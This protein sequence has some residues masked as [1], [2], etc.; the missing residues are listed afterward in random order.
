MSK[1][2][3]FCWVL[4]IVIALSSC[5]NAV[6]KQQLAK[7]DSLMAVIATASAHLNKINKDTVTKRFQDYKETNKKVF[8][9]YKEYR[10][11]ENWKYLCAFQE[12][13]K[14]FKTVSLN[15]NTYMNELKT[16]KKQLED[17][18]YDVDHKLI[19][20]DEFRGFFLIEAQSADRISYKINT[21][22]EN[23]LRQYKNFDTVHP[24]LLKL[25][26]SYPKES[27]AKK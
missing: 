15:Y 10:N 24:Y 12:V 3:M 6:K 14:A 17:L 27:T 9:H 26:E 4:V 5:N 1:K 11:D 13:R 25:I 19:S 20:K 2:S 21:Q 23:V 18:K 8:E 16:S 7:V 22:V